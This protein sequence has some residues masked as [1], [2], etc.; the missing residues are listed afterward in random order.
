MKYI[1]LIWAVFFAWPTGQALQQNDYKATLKKGTEVIVNLQFADTI[2]VSSVEGSELR[3]RYQ[4]HFSDSELEA[5]HYLNFEPQGNVFNIESGL[6]KDKLH[7]KSYQ[8]S[9]SQLYWLEVPEGCPLELK[10]ISGNIEVRGFEA[11][12]TAESISGFVDVDWNNTPA[13]IEMS[14]V[15]GQL[16]TDLPLKY[17]T[18]IQDMPIVGYP[19]EAQ[20]GHGGT[21]VQLRSVSNDVF[22]RKR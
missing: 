20:L 3:L 7:K 4:L 14:S 21:K 13:N 16:Y 10:T 2:F 6:K 5:A 9:S 12:I 17:E 1:L 22:L 19:I 11:A 15:T 18:P 8:G